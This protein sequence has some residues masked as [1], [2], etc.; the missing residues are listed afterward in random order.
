MGLARAARHVVLGLV[1]LVDPMC[2]ALLGGSSFG[3]S[4]LWCFQCRRSRA[5]CVRRARRASWSLIACPTAIRRPRSR[6][7]PAL[8]AARLSARAS[9]SDEVR[10]AVVTDCSLEP[11]ALDFSVLGRWAG[12]ATWFGIGVYALR[13]AGGVRLLSSTTSGG[14]FLAVSLVY[15]D[16]RVWP[17]AHGS[18]ALCTT[19]NSFRMPTSAAPRRV[20]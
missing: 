20:G 2:W 12:R 4:S 13:H 15:V 10:R 7:L 14:V 5:Y 16:S 11:L 9:P 6:L 8:L 1:I 18:D 3:S 17:A 19:I